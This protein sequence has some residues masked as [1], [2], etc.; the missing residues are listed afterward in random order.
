MQSAAGGLPRVGGDES[1]SQSSTN[2][3]EKMLIIVEIRNTDWDE[4]S[5]GRVK[6]NVPAPHPLAA[7]LSRHRHQG[8]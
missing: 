4:I 7:G 6:R 5:T 3:H 2:D 1:T 8:T